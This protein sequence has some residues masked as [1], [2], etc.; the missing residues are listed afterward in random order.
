[1]LLA[2]AVQNVRL[3][4]EPRRLHGHKLGVVGCR[5]GWVTFESH[6]R[7]AMSLAGVIVTA[8]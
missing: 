3:G 4:Q 6:S 2:T 8:Q 7:R 5:T 1:M